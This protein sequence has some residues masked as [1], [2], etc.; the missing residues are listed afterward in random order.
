MHEIE[1][2]RS[3]LAVFAQYGF[4]RVSMED[5]G[6]AL[7]VSRQTVYNRFRT[8]EA[9]WS[10]AFGTFADWV[11]ASTLHE[12]QCDRPLKQRI[13]SALM[14]W[15]GDHVDLLQSSPHGMEILERSVGDMHVRETDP[16]MAFLGTLT[17]EIEASPE[18][19]A[20]AAPADT[21]FVLKIAAKGLMATSSSSKA[22]ERDIGRIV[23]VLIG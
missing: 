3:V 15:S 19:K 4:R 1:E 17:R 23:S 21:A 10:W 22:F 20:V 12:L 9:V 7:G 16:E 11:L 14:R 5:I 6:L 18:Y 13:V 2:A 8:K